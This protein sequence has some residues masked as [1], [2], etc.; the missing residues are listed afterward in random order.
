[1]TER[2]AVAIGTKHPGGQTALE[3]DQLVG[4]ECLEQPQF[5]AQRRDR[6]CIEQ[7]SS[8]V[9]ETGGAREDSVTHSVRQQLATCR[10]CFGDVERVARGTGMQLHRIDGLRTRQF[11]H[12]RR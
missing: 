6:D 2:D 11:G 3:V 7:L 8:L 10:E 12:R 4:R 5:S 9:I 1:M